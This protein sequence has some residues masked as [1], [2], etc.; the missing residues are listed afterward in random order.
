MREGV[1]FATMFGLGAG[2]VLVGVAVSR[3]VV[4]D[5]PER[6]ADEPRVVAASVNIEAPPP[7]IVEPPPAVVPVPAPAPVAA[8]AAEAPAVGSSEA[9]PAIVSPPVE[10]V[11]EAAP[12]RQP[13]KIVRKHRRPAIEEAPVA[14]ASVPAAEAEPAASSPPVAH[15]PIAIVRGGAAR[16]V[17]GTR[18]AGPRIIHVDPDDGGR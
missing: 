11:A 15:G 18:A 13:R 6:P 7:A 16:P 17:E 3:I 5:A 2:A 14:T 1:L 9:P 4:G 10:P 8:V 12:R